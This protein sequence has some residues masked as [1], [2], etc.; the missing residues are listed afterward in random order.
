MYFHLRTNF[1]TADCLIATYIL[2]GLSRLSGFPV[3][4]WNSLKRDKIFLRTREFMLFPDDSNPWNSTLRRMS[5]GTFPPFKEV[6]S[7]FTR[8]IIPKKKILDIVTYR[9][10]HCS[11]R[12]FFAGTSWESLEWKT[13]DI[14]TYR[15]PFYKARNLTSSQKNQKKA[16]VRKK[17]KISWL[18]KVRIPKT[19]IV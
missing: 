2:S 1:F 19:N 17:N 12:S 3:L 14:W 9:R 18:I 8:E 16:M 11:R 5:M 10:P 7:F 6:K 13:I 4:P 15:I